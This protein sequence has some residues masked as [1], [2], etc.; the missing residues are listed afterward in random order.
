LGEHRLGEPAVTSSETQLLR[1][2]LARDLERLRQ[3]ISDMGERVAG[4]IGR[5][6]WAFTERNPNLSTLVIDEDVRLNELQRQVHELSYETILTQ[7]PV[8]TDLREIMSLLHMAGELE[9]MGDHCVSIA[10][11]ARGL[12]DLPPLRSAAGLPQLAEMCTNQVHDILSAVMERDIDQA[13][14]VAA[15]DDSIDRAYHRLFDELVAVM[16]ADSESVF[17]A[18]NV[19]FMSHYLERIGDRV[20]NIAEDLVFQE[21]GRIEE[22]G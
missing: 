6:V 21:T 20:T 1:P 14:E 19:I 2:A 5:S 17:Q 22:L 18:T 12:V 16:T 9:R 8:A 4:A 10:R 15:R 3:M 11:L 13:R 7:A